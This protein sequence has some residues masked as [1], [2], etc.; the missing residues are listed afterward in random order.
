MLLLM[1]DVFFESSLGS[2]FKPYQIAFQREKLSGIV[3]KAIWCCAKSYLVLCEKLSGIVRKAIW[4][5][6]KN[7]L[8]LCEKLSDIVRKAIWYC[9]KSYLVLCEKLSGIVRKAIWYCANSYL[10]LC[11]QLSGILCEQLSH[12]SPSTLEIGV[13]RLCSVTEIA[14]KSPLLFVNSSP[15]W[16]GLHA[17]AKVI[18]ICLAVI[19]ISLF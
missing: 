16:Y 12:M 11:E 2:V 4:Y 6:V 8:V 13:A 19:F 7:Y 5:C 17:G 9:A 18:L 3:R 14:P 1:L 10:V 15:I